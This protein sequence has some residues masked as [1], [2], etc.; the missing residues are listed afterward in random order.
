V[1]RE[2][3]LVVKGSP[4]GVFVARVVAGYAYHTIRK[5]GSVDGAPRCKYP[6]TILNQRRSNS[7]SKPTAAASHYGYRCAEMFLI[8]HRGIELNQLRN[9][10]DVGHCS[11]QFLAG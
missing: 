8:A 5:L 6:E 11:D 3:R 1:L 10:H 4:C 2:S 9:A 7:A